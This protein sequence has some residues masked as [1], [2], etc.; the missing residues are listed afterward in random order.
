MLILIAAVF[1]RLNGFFLPTTYTIV[2]AFAV[3]SGRHYIFFVA[4]LMREAEAAEKA[5]AE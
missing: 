1:P 2:T 5:A 3:L 4:R